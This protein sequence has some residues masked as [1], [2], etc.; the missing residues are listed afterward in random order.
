MEPE[1]NKVNNLTGKKYIDTVGTYVTTSTGLR[2]PGK[3]LCIEK[4]K[5]LPH[6][7]LAISDTGNNRLVIIN[8]ET[9]ECLWSIGC[10]KI[11]LVDGN[12]EEACFH[13]P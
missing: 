11:G 1:E 10:S 13:H 3:L 5:G 12:F 2:Y 6:N 4:Q 7:I 8:E 9:K